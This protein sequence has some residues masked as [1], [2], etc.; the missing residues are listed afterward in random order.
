MS[1]IIHYPNCQIGVANFNRNVQRFVDIVWFPILSWVW[2][3]NRIKPITLTVNNDL[4]KN[5]PKNY[6]CEDSYFLHDD[7]VGHSWY[8]PNYIVYNP[9]S[10]LHR[11]N[12]DDVNQLLD[13]MISF[14]KPQVSEE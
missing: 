14:K 4:F 13:V 3:N 10:S 11:G 5:L 6:Q 2:E 7:N 8:Y 1:R 12:I 9:Y